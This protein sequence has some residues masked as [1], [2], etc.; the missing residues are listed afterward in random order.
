M[1]S[2]AL[3]HPRCSWSER[4]PGVR[5]QSL[6]PSTLPTSERR[7]CGL[8][9]LTEHHFRRL[10][11]SWSQSTLNQGPLVETLLEKGAGGLLQFRERA[12]Q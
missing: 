6:P 7:G 3:K 1:P 10:R 4:R 8:A 11:E 12:G 5:I 2:R 9:P